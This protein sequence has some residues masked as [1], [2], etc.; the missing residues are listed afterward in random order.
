MFDDDAEA[1]LRGLLVV[2][3]TRYI[4]GPYCTMLMADAGATVVKVEPPAGDD[5]RILEP[6]LLADDGTE[7]SSYFLRMNRGK[8][9]LALDLKEGG[10]RDLLER[11]IA[12]ADVVVENYAAGVF[13]R[14]GFSESKIFE[15]NRRVVY[16]SISG[17][18]HSAS[19]MRDRAAYNIVAE[20]EAGVFYQKS[21]GDTP[22]PLGPPVGDMFPAMHALSGVCSWRSTGG[23][24]QERVVASISRC[25]TRCCH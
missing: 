3:L 16:A 6:H 24:G 18:G 8:R 10:D 21:P 17:F 11:L 13:E 9:S 19:P 14:L 5:T 4:A 20:Y 2:D 7:V 1:P 23:S 25:S 12:K 15:L 22:A